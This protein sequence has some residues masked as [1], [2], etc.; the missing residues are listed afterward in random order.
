MRVLFFII[1]S[2]LTAN[3][4]IFIS[5]VSFENGYIEVSI[6]SDESIIGFQF[7]IEA[8]TNLNAVFPV[9]ALVLFDQNLTGYNDAET[10]Y[11][12][13]TAAIENGFTLFGNE[14]LIIGFGLDG[15]IV[16]PILPSGESIILVR[17]PWTFDVN[18]SGTVGIGEDKIFIK[19]GVGGLP[20]QYIHT[21][22][23]EEYPLILDSAPFPDE[24]I[25]NKAFPNPFNPVTKISYGIP[26]S[27]DIVLS[28]YDINGRHV[29]TL[30]RGFR[31][32]GYYSVDWDANDVNGNQISTGLYIYQLIAGNHILSEKVSLVK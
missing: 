8:S 11:M 14:G 31:S 17:I 12:S 21:T 27:S 23:T 5:N 29:K 19:P 28:I 30:D 3:V 25:L 13:N 4:D 32:A 1:I 16:D 24:F 7:Q 6:D 20:P 26:I 10:P 18:Q 22:F 2:L 15:M 9:E